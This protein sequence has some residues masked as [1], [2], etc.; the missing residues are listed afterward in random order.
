MPRCQHPRLGTAGSPR[1]QLRLKSLPLT[2]ATAAA[3]QQLAALREL[4]HPSLTA[5]PSSFHPW[6]LAAA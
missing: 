4:L 1:A 6:P 5:C 2:P 3:N